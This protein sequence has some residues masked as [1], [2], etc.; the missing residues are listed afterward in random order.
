MR[1]NMIFQ[2]S[3]AGKQK[4]AYVTFF[5]IASRPK[6]ESSL[7]FAISGSGKRASYTGEHIKLVPREYAY[8]F[9]SNF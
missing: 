8:A 4:I 3:I 5:N 1:S 7:E 2:N 6:R 9:E